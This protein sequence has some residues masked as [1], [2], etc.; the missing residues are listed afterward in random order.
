MAALLIAAPRPGLLT[1]LFVG[2]PASLLIAACSSTSAPTASTTATQ[3]AASPTIQPSA[4]R[5]ASPNVTPVPTAAITATPAAT[6]TSAEGSLPDP[7][8]LVT[9]DEAEAAVGSALTDGSS[10]LFSRPDGTT[11]RSCYWDATSGPGTLNF[12]IWNATPEQAAAY[13]EE[14][15]Q[16]GDVHDIAGLGDSAYRVGF[17]SLIVMKNNLVLEYGIEMAD[18]DPDT[19]QANLMTLATTALSRL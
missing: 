5:T 1:T 17:T 15:K 10:D 2:L 6:P 13:K 3:G 14:Q 8:V 12:D 19:A 18:Y 7:C 16:F 11:G 9:N 4:A